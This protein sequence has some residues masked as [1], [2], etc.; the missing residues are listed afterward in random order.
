MQTLME[1]GFVMASQGAL[2]RLPQTSIP[3]P[4]K[5]MEAVCLILLLMIAGFFMI[6]MEMAWLEP[7]TFLVY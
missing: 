1:M 4:L 7:M 2:M 3:R 5:T 6:A